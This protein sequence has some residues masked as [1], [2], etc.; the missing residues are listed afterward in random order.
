MAI[1]FTKFKGLVFFPLIYESNRRLFS[2]LLLVNLK[3]KIKTN[4][5]ATCQHIHNLKKKIED[6][7]YLVYF[8][9]NSHGYQTPKKYCFINMKR[10]KGQY[11]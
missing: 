1:R 9:I 4:K 11:I 6:I 8:A 7:L 2:S 10:D 5:V 3:K